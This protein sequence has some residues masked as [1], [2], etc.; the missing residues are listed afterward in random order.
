MNFQCTQ[1]MRRNQVDVHCIALSALEVFERRALE[2]RLKAMVD[3]KAA[4]LLE[5]AT[6][7][8]AKEKV[9]LCIRL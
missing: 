8:T 4:R 6:Q 1:M 5:I 3:T 2:R 9:L 7:K